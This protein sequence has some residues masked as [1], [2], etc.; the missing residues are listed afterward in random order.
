MAKLFV[1]VLKFHFFFQLN[2]RF[3]RSN[4]F[5][6]HGHLKSVSETYDRTVNNLL[7]LWLE[8]SNFCRKVQIRT[9]EAVV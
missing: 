9:L 6:S 7:G 2:S 1:F 8:Q 4:N 3:R 5:L